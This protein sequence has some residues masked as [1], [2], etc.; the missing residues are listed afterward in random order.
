MTGGV[1]SKG[2]TPGAQTH[3]AHVHVTLREAIAGH[4]RVRGDAATAGG[5][6]VHH[7]RLRGAGATHLRQPAGQ[8]R[9]GVH[10]ADAR[11]QKMRAGVLEQ[12][13]GFLRQ[14]HDDQGLRVVHEMWLRYA[15]AG[16]AILPRSSSD[17]A[18]V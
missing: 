6:Q 9:R 15:R 3:A 8:G 14:C 4:Q 12:A 17:G 10:L 16:S 7:Q 13:A 2:V 18:R 1:A 11:V 5:A